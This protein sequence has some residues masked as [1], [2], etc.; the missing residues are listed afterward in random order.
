MQIAIIEDSKKFRECLET[1]LGMFPDCII[2]YSLANA[3]N[4]VKHFGNDPPDIVL[5]DI[6]MPGVDGIEAVS[7]I[8]EHYPH[9]QCIVLTI[10]I[11]LN[12]VVKAIAVG[13]K[14]YLVKDKDNIQKIV[15]SIRTLYNGNFN[16]E[17]PLNGSLANKLLQFFGDKNKAFN[18]RLSE[19]DLTPRQ[20]EIL[21]LLN[22]GKSYKQI[23]EELSI[24]IETLNSHI[25]AIYPKVRVNS[26][27]E[28]QQL[29]K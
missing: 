21:M 1:S 9:T 13:A 4:I 8:T 22:E 11:D 19:F 5:V 14:G 27:S 7:I 10:N 18:E 24:S 29:F 25:K 20:K 17:F 6:N 26:R 3:L 16:E 12:L 23:A 28:L 15:E 2:K